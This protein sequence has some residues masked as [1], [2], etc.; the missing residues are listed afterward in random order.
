M[1]M[2]LGLPPLTQYDAAATPMWASFQATP[3]LRPYKALTPA[4]MLD[5]INVART[6]E[7]RE[8]EQ[9]NFEREDRANED[10]FNRILWRTI[11]GPSVTYPGSRRISALELKR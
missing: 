11:K 9:L 1:E 10:H 2:I 3:D 8:S 7:S 5:E 4:V 6:S